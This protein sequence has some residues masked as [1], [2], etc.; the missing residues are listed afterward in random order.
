M[1]ASLRMPVRSTNNLPMSPIPFMRLVRPEGAERRMFPRKEYN[2]RVAGRRLGHTLEARREPMLNLS[3]R[4]VS[5]GGLSAIS[6][7]EL[8]EG[9]RISVFFPPAGIQKGWDACGR[10]IRC[11]PSGFGYKIAVEF[12]RM[13]LAA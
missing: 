8:G 4:D 5:M 1:S 3:L 11:E 12:E 13:P 2:A 7:T 9:E 10:V 6:Q